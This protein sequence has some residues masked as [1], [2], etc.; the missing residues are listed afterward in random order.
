[1]HL[2]NPPIARGDR[3][4]ASCA[5]GWGAWVTGQK[6]DEY[7]RDLDFQATAETAWVEHMESV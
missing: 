7:D 4:F 6:L 5:C 2:M 1:M 3:A